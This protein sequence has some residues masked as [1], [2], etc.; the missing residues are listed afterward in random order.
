MPQTWEDMLTTEVGKW[1]GEKTKTQNILNQNGANFV[2]TH[3]QDMAQALGLSEEARKN[4]VPYP[5]QTNISI[6]TPLKKSLL[7]KITLG[8]GLPLLTTMGCMAL[9]YS[10]LLKPEPIVEQPIVE[11]TRGSVSLE[12]E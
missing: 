1:I 4:I 10:L 11:Q 3:G 9:L 6:T 2:Y 12:V 7:P 5:S 8:V